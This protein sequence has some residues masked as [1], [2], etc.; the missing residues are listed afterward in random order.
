MAKRNPI[1]KHDREAGDGLAKAPGAVFERLT[2]RQKSDALAK[3]DPLT[4]LGDDPGVVLANVVVK[5]QNDYRDPALETALF[6]V[7]LKEYPEYQRYTSRRLFK[8]L[9][10]D[11]KAAAATN[12]K[13]TLQ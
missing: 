9:E 13:P 4:R 12:R 1:E 2:E 3:L 5:L 6:H 11:I 7:F 8:E 10:A